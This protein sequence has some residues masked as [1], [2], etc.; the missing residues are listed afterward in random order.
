[1]SPVSPEVAG[2]DVT[3]AR[4]VEM[5]GTM[6]MESIFLSLV[7]AKGWHLYR[8]L[9]GSDFSGVV[10]QGKARSIARDVPYVMLPA[11]SRDAYVD[12][13]QIHVVNAR[14][15]NQL[16]MYRDSEHSSSQIEFVMIKKEGLSIKTKEEPRAYLIDRNDI[17]NA[18]KFNLSTYNVHSFPSIEELSEFFL[19]QGIREQAPALLPSQLRWEYV[20]A[21]P[22]SDQVMIYP[23][24]PSPV[25][26]RGQNRRYRPCYPTAARGITA[27]VNALRDLPKGERA[28]VILNLI[29]TQWFNEN[30]RRTRC[31]Q[32]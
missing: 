6:G 1:M 22:P 17:D 4:D 28:L 12:E 15:T 5:D 11:A 8:A 24:E 21:S 16:P 3:R 32:R 23:S 27:G 14:S 29:R 13:V 10:R 30:L 7:E 2:G 9:R 25:L 20:Q 19:R 18:I 26:F 31:V